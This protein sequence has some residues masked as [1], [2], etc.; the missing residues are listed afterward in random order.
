[1]S[2]RS[3]LPRTIDVASG[4]RPDTTDRRSQTTSY[5]R[6]PRRRAALRVRTRLTSEVL[7]LA[8]DQCESAR[9]PCDIAP[10]SIC[11]K[12]GTLSCRE[13]GETLTKNK[14]C[15]TACGGEV[16][17]LLTASIDVVIDARLRRG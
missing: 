5:P 4:Q 2:R 14:R 16:V 12:C 13:H 3:A 7:E 10:D 9:K 17:D 6:A 15:C 1:M 11:A 8:F